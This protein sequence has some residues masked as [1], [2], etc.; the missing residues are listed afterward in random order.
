MNAFEIKQSN[1]QPFID[2]SQLNPPISKIEES[3]PVDINTKISKAMQG[4]METLKE[5]FTPTNVLLGV[6]LATHAVTILYPDILNHG[7]FYLPNIWK[8]EVW[9]LATSLV[10]HQGLLHLVSNMHALYTEGP[11]VEKNWGARG[12]AQISAIATAANVITASV[13][14]PTMNGVGFSG[15]LSGME[16][17]LVARSLKEKRKD[18]VN[19]LSKTGTYIVKEYLVTQIIK[20]VFGM[21]ISLISHVSGFAGGMIFGWLSTSSP[22]FSSAAQSDLRVS[23]RS[24]GLDQLAQLSV[25]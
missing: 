13:V 11:K 7:S 10:L 8:G 24:E 15:V 17:A 1:S 6:C 16:G 22:V 14:S 3:G 20:N 25:D 2:S 21:N 9:R 4:A 23:S 5:K 18:I 12:F 19:I